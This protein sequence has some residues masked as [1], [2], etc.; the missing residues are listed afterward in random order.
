MKGR[1]GEVEGG[2]RGGVRGMAE[3]REGTMEGE[4]V[5]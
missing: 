2:E 1:G 3:G 5:S 4:G